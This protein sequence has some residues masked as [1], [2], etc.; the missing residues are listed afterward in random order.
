[1]ESDLA[2]AASPF[3][4]KSVESPAPRAPHKSPCPVAF[5]GRP[6]VFPSSSVLCDC[7]TPLPPAPSPCE[8]SLPPVVCL[9]TDT[10]F[11]VP[12]QIPGVLNLQ[13]R[14][15]HRVAGIIT[16]YIRLQRCN[17]AGT[18]RLASRTWIS[19]RT[20]YTLLLLRSRRRPYRSPAASTHSLP[21]DS[22]PSR[23]GL[24]SLA[25]SHLAQNPRHQRELDTSKFPGG[26]AENYAHHHTFSPS[27]NTRST[28][29]RARQR[30]PPPHAAY[31]PPRLHT[32]DLCDPR[33]ARRAPTPD[34]YGRTPDT[35]TDETTPSHVWRAHARSTAGP[36]RA[37]PSHAAV[38]E[39]APRP[40]GSQASA[41]DSARTRSK[42]G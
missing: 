2:C 11:V 40:R 19:L 25:P 23:S 10:F 14:L 39:C 31:T 5:A 8:Y 13:S 1:M 21:A 17:V 16:S 36:A 4:L 35:R 22:L 9:C 6:S 27:P 30:H 37:S 42:S 38:R 15:A 33:H 29:P 28:M 3:T 18:R 41:P 26:P 34:A 20:W 32:S 12:P 24:H 7:S